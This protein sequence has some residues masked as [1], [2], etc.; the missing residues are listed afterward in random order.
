MVVKDS[1]IN[2]HSTFGTMR[3]VVFTTN[4]TDIAVITVEGVIIVIHP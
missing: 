1:F 3:E 4:S 2:A